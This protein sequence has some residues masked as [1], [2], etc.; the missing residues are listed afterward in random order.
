M[1]L[2]LMGWLGFS[3]LNFVRVFDLNTYSGEVRFSA[4]PLLNSQLA[5]QWIFLTARSGICLK[6]GLNNI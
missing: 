3:Q 2:F 6:S 4:L 1:T 5:C